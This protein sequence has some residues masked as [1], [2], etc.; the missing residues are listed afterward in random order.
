MGQDRTAV[1]SLPAMREAVANIAVGIPYVGLGET[2]A[3]ALL[4]VSR[5]E[6]ARQNIVLALP[7]LLDEVEALRHIDK[8]YDDVCCALPVSAAEAEDE[9]ED[10][11][12]R[13]L[14]DLAAERIENTR[15][16]EAFV[17]MERA[18]NERETERDTILAHANALERE[19]AAIRGELAAAK[20]VLDGAQEYAMRSTRP[21]NLTDLRVDHA[22]WLAWRARALGKK[23]QP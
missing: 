3:D 2:L 14:A 10:V 9:A 19:S 1:T 5:S 20:A 13:L 23:E 12:K 16:R 11:V 4:R 21:D 8:L 17:V 22:A 7:A 15:L 6:Q 18:A